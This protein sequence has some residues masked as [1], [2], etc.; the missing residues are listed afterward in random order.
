MDATTQSHIF[1]PFFTTKEP[2]K[3]TGLGLATV[4]GIVKQSGGFV[5]AYS[6]VGQGTTFKIYLPQAAGTSA[7]VSESK[8][9]AAPTG[10]SETILIAE[11][12]PGV[13][14]LVRLVLTSRGY[15]VLEARNGEDAILQHE[16]HKGS[17]HLLLTDV[18]MPDMSGRELAE[19]LAP[20]HRE[21]AVLYMS[22][23]TDD[24]IARHG[25][26]EAGTA[27][28][29]KPFTPEALARK[30]REVLDARKHPRG[31]P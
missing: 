10:G 29:Q 31:A 6:E 9:V 13:R 2:G 22:G 1:E 8:P 27:F 7:A 15:T 24:A 23:Y 30:V 28:I 12:E 20:F 4:Y 16:M 17:L 19:R 3:G 14:A 21:M 18:I 26:L 25:I 5:W 11:D